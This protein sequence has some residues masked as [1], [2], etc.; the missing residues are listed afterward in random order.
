MARVLKQK[1]FSTEETGDD[2]KFDLVIGTL[3]DFLM[4]D[5]FVRL[6]TKF[7]EKNYMHYTSAEENSLQYTI[8]HK[9]YED[10]VEASIFKRLKQTLPWF[11][12]EEFLN[13]LK[14][15]VQQA[16]AELANSGGSEGDLSLGDV[17]DM[18]DSVAN[19]KDFKEM[20][21]SYKEV[22]AGSLDI[23]MAVV[24]MVGEVEDAESVIEV[25]VE[26]EEVETE[27]GVEVDVEVKEEVEDAVDDVT[28]ND[29]AV[30][31]LSISYAY[32]NL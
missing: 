29:Y 27:G 8:D 16:K 24:V 1:C 20:M 25:E 7:M 18:L 13:A 17:F 22:R 4:D 9:E 3:E 32:S 12:K 6:Q 26:V 10:L 11:S 31:I 19:F 30:G 28:I 23:E 15:K 2:W 14:A 21:L 5:A